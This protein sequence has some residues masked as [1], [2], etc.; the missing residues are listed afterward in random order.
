MD[1]YCDEVLSGRIAVE[2][3]AETEHVLAFYHTKPYWPVHVVI[4]PKKHIPS[5]IDLKPSDLPVLQEMLQ[6]ASELCR[7]ITAEHGGCRLSTNIGDY[8][9]TQHLHF[10]IHSGDRIREEP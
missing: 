4:I 10:Y 7:R 5:L 9:T 6:T 2:K 8:Q 3:L 1:F